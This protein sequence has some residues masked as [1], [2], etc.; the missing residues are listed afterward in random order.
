MVQMNTCLRG[1]G[2]FLF[3]FS[4]RVEPQPFIHYND[5]EA[6]PHL[7]SI[8]KNSEI[9]SFSISSFQYL[10]FNLQFCNKPNVNPVSV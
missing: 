1:N 3:S 2:S 4:F 5:V 10:S 9:R 8:T 6:G 7:A